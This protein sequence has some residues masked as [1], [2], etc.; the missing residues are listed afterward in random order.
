[1]C[2]CMQVY[3]MY[4][5][6]LCL[7][8]HA[9]SPFQTLA[10][11]NLFSISVIYLFQE[12]CV[13]RILYNKPLILSFKIK[14]NFFETYPSFYTYKWF[15]PFIAKYYSVELMCITVCL[16][17]HSLK[18][19]WVFSSLGLWWIMVLWTLGYMLFCEHSFYFSGINTHE[20]S[21]QII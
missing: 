16:N 11:L 14:Y 12:R 4:N 10:T 2:V 20:G 7:P 13:N 21:C 17:I 19:I 15:V 18:G 3:P 8:P 6:F 9:L 1:M 5:S